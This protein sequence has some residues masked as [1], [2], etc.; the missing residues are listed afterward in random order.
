MNYN[1]SQNGAGFIANES[2]YDIGL[3]SSGIETC[4][5]YVFY[6]HQGMALIHDTGQTTIESIIDLA[7]RCGTLEKAYYALNP[8]YV[9]IEEYRA[10]FQIHRQRRR[11]IHKAIGLQEELKALN[12]AQGAILVMHNKIITSFLSESL[13]DLIKSPH[14]EQREMINMLNDCFIDNNAQSIPL[15]L[16]FDTNT[17]TP[18]PK[19]LKSKAQM[20]QIARLQEANLHNLGYLK[21]LTTAENL[22]LFV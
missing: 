3:Y 11:Q 13:L 9:P 21:L 15:D 1:I 14:N 16:Q 19:L 17:F 5:V 20:Q 6:G 12:V 4:S 22:D 7:K 8:T 10:K 18:L 2:N